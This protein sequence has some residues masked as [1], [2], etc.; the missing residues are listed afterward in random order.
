MSLLEVQTTT[1]MSSNVSI[2]RSPEIPVEPSID[3]FEMEEPDQPTPMTYE[4]N[5]LVY[6]HPAL[7]ESCHRGFVNGAF[8]ECVKPPRSR[9]DYGQF[10]LGHIYTDRGE[11]LPV[12]KITY[13]TGHAPLTSDIVAASRHY[14]NTGAVG[15]Y[16][17]A[18]DGKF[19][20]W[21]SGVLRSDITGAGIQSLRANPPSGDWR[22]FQRNLEMVA[23]LAVPV[24]G[25]AVPQLSLA[26]S[27]EINA[28]ILPS[29]QIE[30]EMEVAMPTYTPAEL[31]QRKQLLDRGLTAAVMSTE[32]RNNLPDSAFA[33]PGR[34]YP[35]NDAA[36][37]R[38]ALARSA[39]K[40][41]EAAVRRAVC[42]KYPDMGECAN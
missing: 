32:T 28:L 17:R 36:H 41:E 18:R 37:A 31:R 6:G 7:W 5:G 40:P 11:R 26:A 13:E 39:G 2:T 1:G 8:S 27:G 14:D 19:G 4:K 12:G 10:H 35:I 20:P 33:L 16:V 3:F 29:W 22:G 21:F 38:N 15:A 9:T 42:R 34:R 23:A 30:L 24:P 25:F